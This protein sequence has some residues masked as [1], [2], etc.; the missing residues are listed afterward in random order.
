M[1]RTY[2]YRGAG[3]PREAHLVDPFDA[4]MPA[5]LWEAYGQPVEGD[6]YMP[7]QDWE[8]LPF[9]DPAPMPAELWDANRPVEGD[10]YMP[11]STPVE[12]P[13]APARVEGDAYMPAELWDEKSSEEKEAAD[14]KT[15]RD[16]LFSAL[17]GAG[18]ALGQG[19]G[20]GATLAPSSV[21]AGSPRGPMPGVDPKFLRP[22]M[23]LMQRQ[24]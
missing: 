12:S 5:A 19:G 10:A 17:K 13:L 3:Y 20:G 23:Q 8:G 15:W 4:Y 22:L 2:P 21:Q 6:A 11:G 9:E 16:K 18:G 1:A 24:P 14:K 7:G